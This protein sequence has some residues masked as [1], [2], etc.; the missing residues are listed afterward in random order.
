MVFKMCW[1]LSIFIIVICHDLLNMLYLFGKMDISVFE[2]K[3]KHFG[4]SSVIFCVDFVLY[5]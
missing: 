5:C 4:Y 3:I 2:R 1:S